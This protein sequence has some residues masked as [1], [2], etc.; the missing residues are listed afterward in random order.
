ML[1]KNFNYEFQKILKNIKT[2]QQLLIY[3]TINLLLISWTKT[4]I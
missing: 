3:K 2:K 1:N 4:L